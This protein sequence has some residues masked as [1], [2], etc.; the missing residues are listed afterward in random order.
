V[1]G[2][3]AAAVALAVCAFTDPPYDYGRA[4]AEHMQQVRAGVER[5]LEGIK[6]ERESMRRK[7]V[8]ASMF[9]EAR[10]IEVRQWLSKILIST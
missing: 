6:S 4:P 5:D 8:E 7:V 10:K 2:V 3:I 9:P 1:I